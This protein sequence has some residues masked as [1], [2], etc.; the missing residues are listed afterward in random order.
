MGVVICLGLVST[1][2]AQDGAAP[3]FPLDLRATLRH[4]VDA[5]CSESFA[6]EQAESELRLHVDRGGRT[7]LTA[8][9]HSSGVYSGGP[10]AG[11]AP[12]SRHAREW[13]ELSGRS[14]FVGGRMTAR[15]DGARVSRIR[16]EGPSEPALPTPTATA[17]SAVLR[18]EAPRPMPV[19]RPP[20]SPEA[21]TELADA[22]ICTLESAPALL[23]SL[24]VERWSFGVGRGLHLHWED[25]DHIG[26]PTRWVARAR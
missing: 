25:S 7:T 12:Y 5:S 21:G 9:T 3:R 14:V 16:W 1:S 8:R 18:C 19:R 26:G 2:H 13:V 6:H 23:A 15:F 11:G 24:G 17:S 20:A 4:E 22:T 10:G